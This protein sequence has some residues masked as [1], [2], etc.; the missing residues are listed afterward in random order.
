MA[1]AQALPSAAAPHQEAV[2][3]Q[4]LGLALPQAAITRLLAVLG[5]LAAWEALARSG[6]VNPLFLS[7]PHDVA[8]KLVQLFGTGVIWPHLW[9]SGQEA[10]FGFGLAILVGVPMGVAM[11]RLPLVRH[12][13]EP[14]I[15]ALYSSPSVAFLPLLILWLG[16]GLWSKVALIFLAAVVVL[17]VNTE[18]GIATVDRRL[19]E[20]A[21][22]FTA[23]SLSILTKVALPFALPC[24]VAG[25]RLA[26]GRVLI[27]VVVAEMFGSTKGLGH[28]IFQ[29][30]AF[31]DTSLVFACVVLLAATGIVC[32]QLLRTMERRLAPWRE[33]QAA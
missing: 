2:P 28:L 14:F 24:I 33:S 13:L 22:A 11:A 10:A 15:M 31:Y 23:G 30:A 8:A 32:N 25:L 7:S 16:T 19:V 12:T 18:A 29:G 5:A 21:Q 3:R 20:M 26:V 9:A 1:V 4:R 6:A 17:I 27:M